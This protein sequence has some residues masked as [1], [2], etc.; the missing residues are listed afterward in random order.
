MKIEASPNRLQGDTDL[1]G[2]CPNC[3]RA[4]IVSESLYEKIKAIYGDYLC[5]VCVS[6]LEALQYNLKYGPRG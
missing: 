6:Q 4:L 5:V 3:D 2:N 1:N